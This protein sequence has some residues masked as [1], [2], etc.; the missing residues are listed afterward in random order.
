MITIGVKSLGVGTAEVYSGVR[1]AFCIDKQ[2][3]I[4]ESSNVIKG[5][6]V[7]VIEED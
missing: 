1:P 6:I 3:I 7:Y 5:E 2:T 4:K